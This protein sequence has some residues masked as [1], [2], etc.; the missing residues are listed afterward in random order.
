MKEDGNCFMK[1]SSIGEGKINS[2]NLMKVKLTY[3]QKNRVMIIGAVVFAWVAY[4]VSVKDTLIAYNDCNELEIKMQLASDAPAKIK[5]IETHLAE[6]EKLS[7]NDDKVST[8]Q[9]LLN[10]VSGYCQNNNIVLKE[11]PKTSLQEKNGLTIETNVFIAE[12]NFGKLL[13]LLYLL[14]Q[15]N[16]LGQIASVDFSSK[17]DF[18]TQKIALTTKV[19]LQNIINN[20]PNSN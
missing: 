9:K 6:I 1:V 18:K 14:E 15:K 20:Q 3:K 16:R 12:G 13:N 7:I 4:S 17:K 11:F 2:N 10:F 8:Q 5:E 19:F